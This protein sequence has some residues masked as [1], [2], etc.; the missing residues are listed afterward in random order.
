MVARPDPATSDQ[1][2]TTRSGETAVCPGPVMFPMAA[3]EEGD[4]WA[5]EFG[6]PQ[7]EDIG[8]VSVGALMSEVQREDQ[9]ARFM[10]EVYDHLIAL[11]G[12][13]GSEQAAAFLTNFMPT[14]QAWDERK[15][16]C[17]LVHGDE[18]VFSTT[19]AMGHS[20]QSI[21][22]YRGGES[23]EFSSPMFNLIGEEVEIYAAPT[24]VS[25]TIAPFY[26]NRD[27]QIYTPELAAR[28][29]IS[30]IE[31]VNA[32][33]PYIDWLIFGA[34][35]LT[36]FVG[37]GATVGA[38]RV[39]SSVGA[40]LL[41]TTALVFEVADGT[42]YITGFIGGKGAG[43]NPLREAFRYV[44]QSAGGGTGAQNAEYIYNTLNIAVGFGG[45]IGLFA[46]SIYATTQLPDACDPIEGTGME[47]QRLT[48]QGAAQRTVIP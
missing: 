7:D 18:V 43:Y 38:I 16:Y 13:E 11:N 27:E 32:I 35:V 24:I 44:G 8:S 23:V 2:L 39:A 46:G 31:T 1:P 40:R 26:T 9:S 48:S 12:G 47:E 14:G 17:K 45:R 21:S 25:S 28:S 42:E 15:H 6:Y 5:N 29:V 22:V 34:S 3:G 30:Q 36:V 41:A 20:S 37:V 33:K 4:K 10:L 19:A